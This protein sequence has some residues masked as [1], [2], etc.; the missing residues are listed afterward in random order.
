MW[1]HLA[2]RPTTLM[3][4]YLY[5]MTLPTLSQTMSVI[6]SSRSYFPTAS[7]ILLA[8]SVTYTSNLVSPKWNLT[9][10]L[11]P[12]MCSFYHISISQ[13]IFVISTT[14]TQT[15]ILI[16]QTSSSFSYPSFNHSNPHSKNIY[17]VS[18]ICQ[19]QS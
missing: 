11:I 4:T 14:S 5:T 7:S 13:E 1:L 9:S 2:L 16:Y 10:S 8:G 19:A 15:R 12:S 3:N 18:I 17:T 6:S